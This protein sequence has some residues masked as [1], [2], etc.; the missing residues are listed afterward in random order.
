M[1][2][3]AGEN[4]QSDDSQNPDN[5]MGPLSNGQVSEDVLETRNKGVKNYRL[6]VPIERY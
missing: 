2:F 4:A 1:V 3:Y 6:Q 5:S